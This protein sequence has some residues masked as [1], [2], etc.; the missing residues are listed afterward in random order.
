MVDLSVEIAG[1]RLRNP[2]MAASGAF[3]Y[4]EE[5]SRVGD[6]RRFGAV[7]T[8]G[9]TLRPRAGS[10]PPLTLETPSGILNSLDP[11]NPGAETV[12]REKIPWLRQFGVPIIVNILGSTYDELT[13]LGAVFSDVEGVSALEVNVGQPGIARGGL[14]FG[15]DARS[16][17][18]AAVAV[19]K[20]WKGPLIVKLPPTTADIAAIARAAVE[21]GADALSLIG[22]LAGMAID[23][24]TRK[25][26]LGNLPG[27][28]SGPA[29]R[30]VAIGCVYQVSQAVGVPVIGMGGVSSCRD[31]VEFMMAGATAVG[32]GSGLLSNPGLPSQ[33]L[34][35]LE[36]YCLQEGIASVSDLIGKAW[37]E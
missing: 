25:P 37:K 27:W 16:S 8:R 24:E 7:T 1:I 33:I 23:L 17:Y 35:D 29:I 5:Y 15:T 31:V 10:Q 3:G 18:R 26:V 20:T 19:R 32:I 21:G 28:L 22:P 2:L 30:P 13:E 14:T 6:I 12:A 11:Q 9:T 4:G 34:G 36:M